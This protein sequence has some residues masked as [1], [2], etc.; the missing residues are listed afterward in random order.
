VRAGRVCAQ[1]S[2]RHGAYSRATEQV[3]DNASRA[4]LRKQASY[5]LERRAYAVT[6]RKSNMLAEE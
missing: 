6:R 1:R 2:E 5:L 4:A 3:C